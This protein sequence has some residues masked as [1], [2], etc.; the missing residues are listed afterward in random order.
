MK[1]LNILS[2]LSLL[3]VVNCQQIDWSEVTPIVKFL[4]FIAQ[5]E[6]IPVRARRIVGGRIAN[7]HQFPFQVKILKFQRILFNGFN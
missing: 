2:V 6:S 1:L 3:I 7:A 4:D 5:K